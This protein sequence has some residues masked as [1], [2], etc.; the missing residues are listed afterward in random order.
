MG[1]V[2]RAGEGGTLLKVLAVFPPVDSEI[3]HVFNGLDRRLIC[4]IIILAALPIKK[5]KL[6][7]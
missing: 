6:F 1:V 4:L 5:R 7:S 3:C 2:G